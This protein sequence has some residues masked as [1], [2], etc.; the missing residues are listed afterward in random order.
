MYVCSEETIND[1]E[2]IYSQSLSSDQPFSVVN[3]EDLIYI[4]EKS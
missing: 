3:Y 4:L 2:N 1:K